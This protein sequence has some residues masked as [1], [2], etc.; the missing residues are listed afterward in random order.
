MATI[1]LPSDFKEFLRLLASRD[2][3]YL[4]VGGYAVGELV[5]DPAFQVLGDSSSWP[6]RSRG[7]GPDPERT[8]ASCV[9][10]ACARWLLPD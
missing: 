6:V 8:G 10:V 7:I 9:E 2:V 4:V 5:R 3:E 1:Q